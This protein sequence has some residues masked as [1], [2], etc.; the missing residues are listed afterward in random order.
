MTKTKNR[1]WVKNAAIIFLTV[2][3]L[4]TF[5]SNTIM[6]RSLPEVAAQ[7]VNSG[8]VTT[9]VR[10]TGTVTA[11]ESYEV[12]LTQ[13]RKIQSVA[14]RVGDQVSVGDV[15]VYLTGEQSDELKIAQSELESMELAYQKALL[16][17]TGDDYARENRDIQNAREA[18]KEAEEER[19]S[20]GGYSE[21]ALNAA[22]TALNNANSAVTKAQNDVAT[23]QVQVDSAQSI[24]DMTLKP[25]TYEEAKTNRDAI[26]LQY[27][28]DYE[29]L[30]QEAESK[31]GT[32][33]LEA[34]MQYLATI[35]SENA[36]SQVNSENYRKAEA[37][38]K[39]TEAEKAL[40]EAQSGN[41]GG[42]EEWNNRNNDLIKAKNVLAQRQQAL[43]DAEVAQV[44]AQSTYDALLEKKQGSKAAIEKVKTCQTALED[45]IFALQDQQRADGITSATN[46]LD[47]SAQKKAIDEKTAEI[48][49]LSRNATGGSVMSEV[50]GTVAAI[51]V[52]AG[53]TAQPD[54]ALVTIQVD[55]RGFS[56]SFAVTTEQ[57]RKLSVGDTAD[58]TNFYWGGDINATI[59]GIRNDPENPQ[60]SKIV[61]FAVSGDVEP[62]SSLTLSVGQ[63]S[64]NYDMIVPN[65][66]LRKDNNGDFVLIVVA[67]STP[68]GNRY[69][70]QRADVKILAEDD[71][72][73]AV[74]GALSSGDFVITTSTAPIEAGMQVR[75]AET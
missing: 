35:Y 49:E 18:L 14:V 26:W 11:N 69:I 66:A 44:T 71:T 29:K 5:L 50:A 21:D 8:S 6:N 12:K 48:A 43:A 2:L 15:L 34:Y 60:S 28:E 27:G 51:G 23:A 41:S 7:Y 9:R 45:L 20:V 53:D 31:R 56:L 58:V 32:T 42:S 65:S 68:L 3:L 40:T 25:L 62:G 36:D 37:Y 67:K 38:F 39:V 63:K 13:S 30:K 61:S 57:S 46:A 74:S 54:T 16:T 22:R 70:A 55:D 75:M 52:T 64:A 4:L 73:T 1:G 19:D 59:T 33:S 47:L 24:L 10:G 17:A 72:N